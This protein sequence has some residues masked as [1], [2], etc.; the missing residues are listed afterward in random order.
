MKKRKIGTRGIMMI[1]TMSI[2]IAAV[3]ITAVIGMIGVRTTNN[4]GIKNYKDTMTDG[5]NTE[6]KTQVESAISI[7]SHYYNLSQDDKL[8][9]E[10]AKEQALEVIRNMRYGSDY[11]KDGVN[12]G[13]F[14]IDDTDYNL[15]MHPILSK[16]EG[17]NRKQLKDQNG[18]LILQ[19][20]MKKANN[21][22]GFNEFYFTKSDGTTVAPK[23]AYSE[24]F[25][26]WNWGI[27][28]GNYVD[29]MR[30][31]V[32]DTSQA[33][34]IVI[35]NI[36]IELI[37]GIIVM[38]I[39]A[40]LFSISSTKRILKPI[41]AL[42]DDLLRFTKGELDFHVNEKALCCKDEIGVLGESLEKVRGTLYQIVRSIKEAS[43]HITETESVVKERSNDSR[44]NSKEIANA[45]NN[46]SQG[47]H[48][49]AEQ[50]Q[51][52]VD[53]IQVM[54]HMIDQMQQK[55]FDMTK[56]SDEM[57]EAGENAS[58]IMAELESRN[59][60]TTNAIYKVAE[61]IEKTNTLVQRIQE[62]TQLITQ[63]A[64]QTNLLSLNAS[65]E[66]ARAGESGKG[67]AVVADEI[68]QLADESQNSTVT[69]EEI[70]DTLL[71]ASG[72]MVKTME[73]LSEQTKE[74][75]SKLDET[76]HKFEEVS[77]RIGDTKENIEVVRES[78]AT[79]DSAKNKVTEVLENLSSISEKN[80]ASTEETS[81]S[82][83]ELNGN[84]DQLAGFATRLDEISNKLKKTMSFFQLK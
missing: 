7:V 16:Q 56:L 54:D 69:I 43:G 11:D 74:Q 28:T 8:S 52:A 80:A 75:K 73:V 20:I 72:E 68:K 13:Y 5:Y 49:Q 19:N 17:T 18:V 71:A 4:I 55:I 47:A 9:E 48:S 82:M 58:V 57:T 27:T 38:M 59:E 66:A 21:G 61:Q 81:A 34:N 33:M 62:S 29:D 10:E 50:V 84:I 36:A 14:W 65:I 37:V 78:A 1:T 63:I 45:V 44:I 39:V 3:I 2:M 25:E 35:R 6:I 23:I 26:P 79:C 76:K 15:V 41:I 32:K 77:N 12:D 31:Q 30:S 60:D 64:S 24:K 42:K 67:F 53:A 40:F 51:D 22:G 46:V 70:I 83:E